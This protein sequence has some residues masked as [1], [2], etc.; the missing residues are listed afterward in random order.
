[1]WMA[2]ANNAPAKAKFMLVSNNEDFRVETKCLNRFQAEPNSLRVALVTGGADTTLTALMHPSVASVVSFDPS[3]LQIHL[4][5]LKLAVAT[6]DLSAAQAAG[7][8][9]RGEGGKQVFNKRLVPKLPKETVDFFQSAG[10]DEIERGILRA[11]NDGPFNKIL[12]KWF[13]DE[14]SVDLTK[15]NNMREAEKDKVLSI[16][17]TNDGK[18]LTTALQT[19]M[20]G[21]P[22]FKA[23]PTENQQVI[24]SAL[25]IA[26][27]STLKGTGMILSDTDNGLL[28][29][30]EFHTDIL[31]NGSPKTL[32]PWLTES[33]RRTLRAKASGLTTFQ[34]K[35]EDLKDVEKFDFVSLSNI[36]DF[37][38]EEAAVTSM[39]GVAAAMLK[40]N[41]ELLVRRAVGKAQG[42]LKQA[43]G[44]LLEG[45]ALQD[46]DY[47]SLFYRSPATVA[48]AKF[49]SPGRALQSSNSD[50]PAGLSFNRIFRAFKHLFS[51]EFRS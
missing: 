26:A 1:M 10:E 13:L 5:Q 42:I 31:L 50:V 41:G 33:G 19:F 6:S 32:P 44:K 4:L 17:A 15:W 20:S 8:L 18:T 2:A 43:G 48:S 30:N 35:A 25:G 45:E 3:P 16:C 28:P 38:T 23:L 40:P 34:G 46:C 14:Q 36:Y 49:P 39:K 7:F 12:R 9:L 29:A 22:W 47:N 51:R 27:V 21:A 37:S 24:L 11:D